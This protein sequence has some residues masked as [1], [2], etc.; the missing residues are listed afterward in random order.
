[1]KIKSINKTQN[2]DGKFIFLVW[3]N[4]QL[5]PKCHLLFH[6][7]ETIEKVLE[8]VAQNKIYNKKQAYK[9]CAEL[10]GA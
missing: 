6:S 3:T 7:F 2:A 8:Y 10:K 4:E 5:N 1:M 9:M